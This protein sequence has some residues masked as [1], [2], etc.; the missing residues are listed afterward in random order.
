MRSVILVWQLQPNPITK[1]EHPMKNKTHLYKLILSS[2]LTL[3]SINCLADDGGERVLQRL[4][5][6]HLNESW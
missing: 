1:L 4:E 2:F 3:F 6:V 5:A